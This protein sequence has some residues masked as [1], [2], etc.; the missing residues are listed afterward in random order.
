MIAD[1]WVMYL[2]LYRG[3]FAVEEKKLDEVLC[4]QLLASLK[5]LLE[6]TLE[7][8][9]QALV[10]GGVPL[11]YRKRPKTH[12]MLPQTFPGYFG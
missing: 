4:S 2:T 1:V 10:G 5:F 12:Y 7:D 11:G 3:V 9:M 6:T 8:L